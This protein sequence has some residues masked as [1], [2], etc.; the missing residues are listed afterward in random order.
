MNLIL[1]GFKGA[2]KT[3]FGKLLAHKMNRPFIDTD[4]II[5]ELYKAETTKTRTTREIYQEIGETAFRNLEKKTIPILQKIDHSIIALGGGFI[6]YPENVEALQK[7][8]TLVFL[9]A[10]AEK[11]KKRLFKDE[12]PAFLN[13]Q[14]P[15]DAFYEMFHEREPIYESIKAHKIDTD[16]LDEAGVIAA[17]QSILL[18]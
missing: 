3:H 12:L 8:G 18:L 5:Q 14:S 1:F 13:K 2:G 7:I 11:L 17:L 16:L 4:E 15:K 6:L 10:S 9:K